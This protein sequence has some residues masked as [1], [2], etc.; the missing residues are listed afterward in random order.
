MTCGAGLGLGKISNR[1]VLAGLNV[2]RERGAGD[3]P[4]LELRVRREDR[5][6]KKRERQQRRDQLFHYDFVRC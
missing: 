2:D 6:R 4:G 5:R 1:H 3:D